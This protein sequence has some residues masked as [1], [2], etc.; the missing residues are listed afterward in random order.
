MWIELTAVFGIFAIG[1]ILFGRWETGTAPWKRLLKLAIFTGITAVIY[2]TL[3]RPWSLIWLG[4]PLLAVIYIHGIWLPRH[5][6]NGWTGE[7]REKYEALRGWK[8]HEPA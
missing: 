6:V 3:G 1:G 7:P 2:F 8:S 5:G 4:V